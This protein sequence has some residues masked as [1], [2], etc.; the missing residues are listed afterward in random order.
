MKRRGLGTRAAGIAVALAALGLSLPAQA[1]FPRPHDAPAAPSAADV[2]AVPEVTPEY[3]SVEDAG[4]RV[5]YHPLARERANGLLKRAIA[6]RA[7]LSSLLGRDVLSAVEIRVAAAPAQMAAL[8]P[9]PIPSGAPAVAFRD[10]RLV[11]MS[12]SAALG[13]DPPDL[14]EHLRHALAHIALDEATLGHD[15]PRWFHEGFAVQFS[16]EDAA[17]R[18]EALCV[19]ALQDRLLGLR[20]VDA[21]FPEGAPGPSLS[22]AEAADFVRFLLDKPARDRFAALIERLRAG[23]PLDRALPTALGA[24]LD[25]VEMS[26]RREM[27]RRYSFVPVFAGATLLWVV[28]AAGIS[29]RRRRLRRADRDDPLPAAARLSLAEPADPPP[30]PEP[31]EL[32]QAILPDPEVPKVEH[33]GRWYTLH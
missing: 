33:G 1:R 11:V 12:L 20:E 15:L 7:E 26:F 28:V 16:G 2:R 22:R 21:R 17:A 10:N 6:A 3:G 14:D 13:G 23:D 25:A 9:L 24:D 27:A 4:I 31:E 19:A 18:A 30:E 32:A 8:A 5:V 29:L